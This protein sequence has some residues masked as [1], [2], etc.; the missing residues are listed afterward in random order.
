VAGPRITANQVTFARLV[1]IPVLCWM[2][3]GGATARLVALFLGT[4]IG[5]T[6]FLDGYLARKYG[7]TVLGGLMDPIADKVFVAAS[8]VVL[9]DLGWAPWW[10]VHLVLVR[11]LLVTALRSSFESRG[12]TLRTT[13]LA[14][15]KTWVQMFVIA[16]VVALRIIPLRAMTVFFVAMAAAA[17][18]AALVA[19][20]LRRRWPGIWI[21]AG[22]FVA[23]TTLHL[24]AGPSALVWALWVAVL[25]VTWV[26]AGDYVT[27]AAREL[28]GARDFHLFDATRVIAA[29]LIPVLTCLCLERLPVATWPLVALLCA[30]IF[31]GG[32]DNL[33][34]HHRATSPL[35]TWAART[36]GVIA[37]LA[38]AL[39][40]P[41]SALPLVLAGL[42]VSAAFTV[43]AFWQHRQFYLEAKLREKPLPAESA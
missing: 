23:G 24:L 19:L 34:A 2:L 14:K 42:G 29:V 18:A 32:L 27:V 25:A 36:L 22:F 38:A 3:Y 15:V 26:S 31:H 16:V 1:A 13:Y 33:L 17:V 9:A 39:L 8:L 21:Y 7:P 20:A 30:E 5:F 10:P 11:E 40:V 6:D 12:R 41:G 35:W 4:A 28:A 37:L 43:A